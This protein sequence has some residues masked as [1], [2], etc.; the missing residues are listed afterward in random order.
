MVRGR[1]PNTPEL[2]VQVGTSSVSA[3]PRLLARLP[4]SYARGELFCEV[5]TPDWHRSTNSVVNKVDPG[6][7][8]AVTCANT[9]RTARRGRAFPV[10]AQPRRPESET[11]EDLAMHDAAEVN[12]LAARVVLQFAF[13]QRAEWASP[14]VPRPKKK[15]NG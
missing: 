4:R 8:A 15:G 7:R 2:T 6:T 13:G 10:Q 1:F 14:D 12:R 11:F 5:A 9:A 3:S